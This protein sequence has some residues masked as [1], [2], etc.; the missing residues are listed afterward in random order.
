MKKEHKWVAVCKESRP[1]QQSS[2]WAGNRGKED[3]KLLLL[4]L[5]A[6]DCGASHH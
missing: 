2:P 4:K 5:G 3:T 6:L 1:L